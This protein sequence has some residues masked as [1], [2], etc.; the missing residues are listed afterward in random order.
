MEGHVIVDQ[1]EEQPHASM[2]LLLRPEESAD[3]LGVSR[4]RLYEL[5]A[6]GELKSIKIGRC[7]RIPIAEL[8]S[9]VARE[10]AQQSV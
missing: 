1:R 5:L 2:R 4:A 7:R 6:R 8:E 9:W 10:L 3:A